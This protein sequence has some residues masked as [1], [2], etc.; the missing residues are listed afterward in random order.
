LGTS[1][2]LKDSATTWAARIRKYL[3]FMLQEGSDWFVV[4]VVSQIKPT[5]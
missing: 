1:K 2:F 4:I 5:D 3:N